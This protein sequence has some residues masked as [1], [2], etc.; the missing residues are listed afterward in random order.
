MSEEG[1]F[2]GGR[3]RVWGR[4]G[5]KIV[6]EGGSGCDGGISQWLYQDIVHPRER[7][8]ESITYGILAYSAREA[9]DFV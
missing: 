7:S 5:R 9:G 4:I 6:S 2:D 3:L 1:G 8:T